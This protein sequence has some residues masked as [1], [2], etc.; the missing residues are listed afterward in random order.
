MN[1]PSLLFACLLCLCAALFAQ[2]NAVPF[3]NQPLVPASIAPLHSGFTLT[4]NGTGFAQGAVVNWNGSPRSTKFVSSG[5]LKA[6]IAPSDVAQA[7]TA[8]V[9]V[10]NPGTIASNVIYF[11]IRESSPVVSM[12]AENTGALYGDASAAD[13]NHDGNLDIVL[14]KSG[15]CYDAVPGILEVFLGKGNGH[16]QAQPKQNF[17]W[18]DVGNPVYGD[19][20]G[21]GKL[22]LAINSY[23]G[24]GGSSAVYLAGSDNTFD[25]GVSV[26]ESMVVAA[27]ADFNHDGNLDLVLQEISSCGF[28][29]AFGKGD[30]TFLTTGPLYSM[31]AC[32]NQPTIGDFN[33]DGNLDL[34]FSVGNA[35]QVFLGNGDG[36]FQTAMEFPAANGESTL[37]AADVNGDGKLDLITNGV[38][39]LL[40]KGDGTFTANGGPLLSGNSTNTQIVMGDFNGDGKLDIVV[41]N[42]YP[43]NNSWLLLGNGD[44]TFRNPQVFSS[45]GK[46]V[47]PVVGDFNNDGKLDLI[48]GHVLLQN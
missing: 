8:S 31:S 18:C 36:T 14:L 17:G 44:G 40:G 23:F 15:D 6:Q 10:T 28:Q 43:N 21:D 25:Q 33:G 48:D 47:G 2:S 20:N 39:V 27:T 29:I 38:S 19:F 3:V 7:A 12:T 42:S 1:R 37:V 26:S 22:D 32:E 24:F 11:Q 41:G 30:G 34:A 45:K 13:L 5:Q 16:F 4:V 46:L 35:V 9:T